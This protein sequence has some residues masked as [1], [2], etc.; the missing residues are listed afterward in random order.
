V[1]VRLAL[2][3]ALAQHRAAR[4]N[5]H[6]T[7]IRWCRHHDLSATDDSAIRSNGHMDLTMIQSG[8]S[9]AGALLRSPEC[10][11]LHVAQTEHIPRLRLADLSPAR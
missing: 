8:T 9:V 11:K 6:G 4:P 2:V 3:T 5:L 10:R 7:P 1:L